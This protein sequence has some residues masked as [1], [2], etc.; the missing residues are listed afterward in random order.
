MGWRDL[1]NE[2]LSHSEAD[3]RGGNLASS[4]LS[5]SNE[6]LNFSNNSVEQMFQV[7]LSVLLDTFDDHSWTQEQSEWQPGL[8][9]RINRMV[10]A[11]RGLNSTT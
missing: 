1:A 3:A 5:R 10:L 4:I 7:G 11:G 8:I 2:Q 6:L 9:H